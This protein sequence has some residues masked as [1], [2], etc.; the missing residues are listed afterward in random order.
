M[1]ISKKAEYAMRAVVAIAKAPRT[2]PLPLAEL[3]QSQEIPQRFLEQIMLLLRRGELVD[4]R[5]GASGGYLL[6]KP[7]SKISLAE[8]LELIDGPI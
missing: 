6:A 3:C 5:R 2:K 7:P 4:S 8:I 1:K